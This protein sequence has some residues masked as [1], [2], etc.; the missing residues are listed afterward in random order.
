MMY[1]AAFVA[2]LAFAHILFYPHWREYA[3]S[4]ALGEIVFQDSPKP[5]N[6]FVLVNI[7]LLLLIVAPGALC[8]FLSLATPWLAVAVIGNFGVLAC[9]F[10]M[11][12]HACY[13]TEYRI[14]Q[15]VLE[16]RS[17]FIAQRSVALTDITSVSRI[18]SI[19]RVMGWGPK[20]TER[21]FCN[22]STDGVSITTNGNTYF[23]SPSNPEVFIV[24]LNGAMQKTSA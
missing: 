6:Y 11:M 7:V 4:V 10:L 2:I 14:N 13:K 8:A 18:N 19:N 17:G 24:A 12:I 3:P 16:M 1:G 5:S 20:K 21:G 15:Q 22:R 9:Y 23:L